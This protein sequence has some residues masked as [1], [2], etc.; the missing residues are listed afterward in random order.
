MKLP[1]AVTVS[2]KNPGRYQQEARA[3]AAEWGLTYFERAMKSPLEPMLEELA[4]VFLVLGGDGWTV[5]DAKGSLFFS[6]G[7]A[8][9]RLRRLAGTAQDEDTILRL[10]E[11]KAGDSLVDCTLGLAADAIVCASVVGPT[12]RVL[13]IEASMPLA[14]IARE[15]LRALAANIE[16]RH[17]LADDVLRTL[18]PGSFDCV[19]IDPMFDEPNRASVQFETLRRFAVHEPLTHETVRLAQRVAR[20]WVVVKGGRRGAELTRL[21]LPRIAVRRASPLQWARLPGGA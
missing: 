9:V 8:Q 2:P 5:H 4:D 1:L 18:E 13:G 20:R 6:P 16:V 7:M 15:G 14:I 19:I 3:R 21:G 10:C 12:G 11:L 17:G